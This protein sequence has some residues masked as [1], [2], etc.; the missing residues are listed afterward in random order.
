MQQES[1]LSTA[2]ALQVKAVR[3]PVLPCPACGLIDTPVLGSGRGP[4]VGELRCQAGH[5]IK[6]A[7]KALLGLREERSMGGI[8]RC[9]VVGS[10]SKHGVEVRYATSGT[11]C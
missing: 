8:A 11:A 7:S 4:H 3:L 6:W 9:T 5:H 10:I 2:E 1:A